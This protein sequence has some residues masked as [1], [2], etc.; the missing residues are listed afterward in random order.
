[1]LLDQAVHRLETEKDLPDRIPAPSA[2]KVRP[3]P[4]R[5][6]GWRAGA[7]A[8]TAPN[9]RAGQPGRRTQVPPRCSKTPG[10]GR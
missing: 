9:T 2:P 5:L 3:E 10:V 1:M 6:R 4:F 7:G 8:Y